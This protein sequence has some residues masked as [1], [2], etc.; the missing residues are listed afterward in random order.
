MAKKLPRP[1]SLLK[2]LGRL[3]GRRKHTITQLARPFQPLIERLEVRVVPAQ[4]LWTAG[5]GSWSTAANWTDQSN[6]THHVP[7][8][9]DD[10]VI[11][12]NVTVTHSSGTDTIH[13]LN[14][15]ST[16]T[17]QVTAGTITVTSSMTNSG[18][19]VV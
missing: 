18:S 4:V 6:S 9:A 2:R 17:L 1:F 8:T 7:G 19:L 10:V 5:S 15:G 11:N 16:S 3:L 14:I 12:T 13:G